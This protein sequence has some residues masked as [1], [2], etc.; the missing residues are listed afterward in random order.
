MELIKMIMDLIYTMVS[1]ACTVIILLLQ[2][3]AVL[4]LLCIVFIVYAYK[5]SKYR[6][7]TYYEQTKCPYFKLQRDK[8]LLGEYYTYLRLKK[9]EQAGAKFLFNVYIPK[10]NGQT[11]EIDVLMITTKGIFVFES[12]NYS[13]WIFGS[14]N[15]KNWY[16]TLPMGK[17]R[18]SSKET[19]LNPIMQNRLHIKSLKLLLGR[20]VIMHSVV[21]FS[22]R[23]TFKGIDV[24]DHKQIVHRE[25]VLAAV[26]SIQKETS[27][28]LTQAD[29]T[30]LY[31]K[32]YPYS[33]VDVSVKE[34]HIANIRGTLNTHSDD[35]TCDSLIVNS[36]FA[37]EITE[38][39][40]QES[41]E[42]KDEEHLICPRCGAVLVLRTAAKGANAGK[43]FYGCSNFPKCRYIREIKEQKSE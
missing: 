11:T 20:D 17:G 39:S 3:P 15:Q 34:K 10:E 18:K 12:K 16:Q 36:A 35:A 42:Q 6:K 26:E 7:T 30:E 37:T 2:T 24:K 31:E 19:F 8:G 21:V 28:C 25:D 1:S 4:L 43:Q 38:E 40:E 14:E 27:D 22:N 5:I 23:C 33:Q 29:I 41:A 32:I 9:H 13:G